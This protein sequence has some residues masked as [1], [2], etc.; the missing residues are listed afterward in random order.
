MY[1]SN[2]ATL[3]VSLA[4]ICGFDVSVDS[5]ID[6]DSQPGVDAPYELVYYHF[7]KNSGA[8]GVCTG[9]T[10]NRSQFLTSR[11]CVEDV[12]ISSADFSIFSH[13]EAEISGINVLDGAD[14]AIVDITGSI[15][16]VTCTRIGSNKPSI[17]DSMDLYTVDTNQGG[18]KQD[19]FIVD[20]N[21]YSAYNPDID[22]ILYDLVIGNL[23][24]G[25]TT[26]EGDS[27]SPLFKE[28][29]DGTSTLYG[30]VMG[31]SRKSGHIIVE[32]TAKYSD[33]IT[34]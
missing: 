17:G 24:S 2:I 11:H 28:S 20:S 22:S 12:T 27:G 26:H 6:I 8:N 31:V 30:I 19:Q 18:I 29:L 14:A 25:D 34:C 23:K 7:V 21:F 9:V 33:S 4:L 13:P 1:V 10:L 16:D 32:P 3:F 15:F 5:G